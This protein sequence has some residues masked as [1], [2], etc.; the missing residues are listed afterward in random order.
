M[1]S[2]IFS[3]TISLLIFAG[4]FWSCS[5]DA[6]IQID[7][8]ENSFGRNGTVII[9]NTSEICL[10]DIDR[11]ENIVA[12]GYTIVAGSGGLYYLTI[13]KTDAKG[14]VDKNFGKNGLVKVTGYANSMPLGLRITNDN[15]I[16]ILGDFTKVQFQGNEA[17]MMRFNEN[18]SVDNSFGDQGRISLNFRAG[19]ILSVNLDNDEFMFVAKL[20]FDNNIHTGYSISK[21]SYSGELDNSFGQNGV[22]YLTNSIAPYCIKILN[23]GSILLAGT[24]N[25]WPNTELGFCKL[26]ADGSADSGF[27]QDGIWHMDLMQDFDIDHEYFS[28]ILEDKDGNLILSGLGIRN[29]QGWGNG[30]FL[31]KFSSQG[32]LITSFGEDGFYGFYKGGFMPIFQIGDKYVTA[33]FHNNSHKLISVTNDGSVGDYIYTCG[34]YYF[35]DMKLRGDNTIILGGGYLTGYNYDANFALERVMVD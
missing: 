23:D 21:Y 9:P 13:A 12:V 26:T 27:A 28:N 25:K 8:L 32:E 14:T 34:M 1:S 15:K 5:K 22:V 7:S 19:Q 35:Q 29:S 16:I 3:F 24:Y 4:I 18:G 30:G 31:S 10:L 20:E 6:E 17:I 11:H 2:K 33:G